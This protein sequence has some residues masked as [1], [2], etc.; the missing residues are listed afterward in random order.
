MHLACPEACFQAASAAECYDQVKRWIVNGN[1]VSLTPFRS[2]LESLCQK[3]LTQDTCKII[4]Y[5][6]PLNLFALTSGKL[7][8]RSDEA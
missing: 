5:L 2:I 8:P 1:S 3:S 4:A 7:R 6:G